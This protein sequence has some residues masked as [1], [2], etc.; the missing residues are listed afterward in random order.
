MIISFWKYKI[1]KKK[2]NIFSYNQTQAGR[3][4][5][6]FHMQPTD[7]ACKARPF[8]AKYAQHVKFNSQKRYFSVKNPL[9]TLHALTKK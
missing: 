9:P 6:I 2:S 5:K 3:N 8:Y 4:K 1:H 7:T